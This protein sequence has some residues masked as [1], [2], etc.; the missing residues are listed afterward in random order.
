MPLYGNVA[1]PLLLQRRLKKWE[2]GA[3]RRVT[4][5]NLSPFFSAPKFAWI[6]RNV[7]NAKELLEKDKLYCG[8]ID[9]WLLYKLTDGVE[10]KTDYSNAS[11]TELLNLDTLQWD[12]DMIELFGLK[13]SALPNACI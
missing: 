11:R 9:A 12:T 3:V 10:F 1:E 2:R 5:L 8:N 13:E 7:A 4:G 6:I